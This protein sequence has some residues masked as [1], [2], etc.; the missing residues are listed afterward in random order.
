MGL[1]LAVPEGARAVR[2]GTLPNRLPRSRKPR[3]LPGWAGIEAEHGANQGQEHSPLHG[4]E[5]LTAKQEAAK[6]AGL[7]SIE[8]EH[9]HAAGQGITS[10]SHGGVLT[11]KQEAAK[12]AGLGRHRG[13]A[14]AWRPRSG[15]NSLAW[16]RLPDRQA[17]SREGGGLALRRSMG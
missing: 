17:G 7:G 9:G 10:P 15:A 6:A 1:G 2:S 8:A 12:A 3:S 5:S 11:A 4:G 16:R 13:G 14:W